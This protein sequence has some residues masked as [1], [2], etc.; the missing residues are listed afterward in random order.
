[1]RIDQN[2]LF[3]KAIVPWYDSKAVCRVIIVCALLALLFGL[4]GISAANATEIYNDYIWL[5]VVL[6]AA[7]AGILIAA[8][9]RLVKQ[10]T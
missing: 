9:I 5:P 7:S 8:V 6:T 10:Y 4:S 3:R 1:M 2:P